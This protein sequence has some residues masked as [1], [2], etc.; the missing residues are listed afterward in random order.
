METEFNVF[1]FH[2][3]GEI[4]KMI[5]HSSGEIMKESGSF[6]QFLVLSLAAAVAF[7]WL[8]MQEEGMRP[9]NYMRR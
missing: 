8:Q 2:G 1:E 6:L 3:S 4:G 7:S 9:V 5:F